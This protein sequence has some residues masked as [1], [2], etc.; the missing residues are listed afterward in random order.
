[1]DHNSYDHLLLV[2]D[3]IES[4]RQY[5]DE[6]MKNLTEDLIAMIISMMY[7]IKIYKSSPDKKDS[8]KAQD[9]NTMFP[10]KKRSP[11]L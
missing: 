8:P 11:P 1:M 9:I 3:K 7:Q 4:N 6:K 2:Q 10:D 5:H